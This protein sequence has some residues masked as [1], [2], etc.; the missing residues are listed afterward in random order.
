M[1]RQ[2]SFIPEIRTEPTSRCAPP[3]VRL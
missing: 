2:Q 1:T 3:A